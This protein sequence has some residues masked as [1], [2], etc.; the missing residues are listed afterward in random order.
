MLSFQHVEDTPPTPTT[1]LSSPL[2]AKTS[3]EATP[4]TTDKLPTSS[5]THP[6]NAPQD[7]PIPKFR[8]I[9]LVTGP[10]GCGKSTVGQYIANA[11]KFPFIEGDKVCDFLRETLAQITIIQKKTNPSVPSPFQHRKNVQRN[12]PNRQRSLGLVDYPP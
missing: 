1:Q 6:S 2:T 5:T 10:A 12:S 11:M 4:Y 8:H 3:S 7:L 9:W